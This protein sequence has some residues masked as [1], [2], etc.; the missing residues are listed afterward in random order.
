MVGISINGSNVNPKTQNEKKAQN[1]PARTT[2]VNLGVSGFHLIVAEYKANPVA[3][4]NP[5]IAPKTL[6]EILS[7][8]IITHTPINAIIIDINVDL[9]RDSPKIKYPTIAAIKGI[10]ANI[11]KVTAAVVIVIEKINP[12]KAVAKNNPPSIDDVPILRKFL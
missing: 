4:I 10:A 1:K 6:P 11:N 5:I 7:L 2:V 12:V 3:D 9:L 8:Y